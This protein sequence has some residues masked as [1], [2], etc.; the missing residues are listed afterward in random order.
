MKVLV[1][2]GAGYI[3][4]VVAEQL[5]VNQHEVEVLD[6]LSTG[7]MSS[8]ISGV[9][10]HE[11]DLAAADQILDS[12][13][14]A[15]IHLAAKSLVG[16]SM[17]HPERYWH[18]NVVASLKLIE[19]ARR[20]GVPRLI[21][22]STAAVYGNPISETISE[23]HPAAPINPYGATKLAI[24][25][26]LT[27]EAAA[28]GLAAVSLRYFNVGGASGPLREQHEPE[29][30][31]IPNLLKVASGERENAQLFGTDYPTH[32]GTAIRDYIH[33]KDLAHAHLLAMDWVQPGVHEIFN[34]GT[35]VGSSV[36]EVI[37]TV[38]RVTGRA[39]PVIESPRRPGDPAVLVSSGDKVE[40]IL[41]W[42]PTHS[43]ESIVSDAWTA[44]PDR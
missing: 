3:G 28:H 30:H 7:H 35:S 33:V 13:F 21:F 34:L 29:T 31:L 5:L 39:I 24:D 18:G 11:A 36:R 20:A 12:S 32:D 15:V 14:D 44:L 41:K 6:N 25:H 23:D 22:S 38:A 1:T 26:M 8:V 4:S 19:A 10:W 43:L 40:R 42:S 9:K 17:Q 2:G 37:D 27:S 16:E